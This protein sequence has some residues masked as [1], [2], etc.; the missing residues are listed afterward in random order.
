MREPHCRS[1]QIWDA[2]STQLTRLS[3]NEMNHTGLRL[4]IALVLQWICNIAVDQ[5]RFSVDWITI[6][7]FVLK[8]RDTRTITNGLCVIKT[9]SR[10]HFYC[11]KVFLEPRGPLRGA[12]VCF[13][14]PQPDTS[15]HCQTTD[16]GLMH[17]VCLLSNC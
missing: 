4:C 3:M 5:L 16:A 11:S 7:Y 13:S 15:L 1:A 8:F 17:R 9:E 6:N 12:D 2:L 14:S 10:S